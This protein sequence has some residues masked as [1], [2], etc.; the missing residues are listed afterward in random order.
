MAGRWMWENK[1][2]YSV[3]SCKTSHLW[4][5]GRC[6]S[7]GPMPF[8]W[9][10]KHM[11]WDSP[12]S[13]SQSSI[14]QSSASQNNWWTCFLLRMDNSYSFFPILRLC[15]VGCLR[16][17]RSKDLCKSVILKDT[18]CENSAHCPLKWLYQFILLTHIRIWVRVHWLNHLQGELVW[19]EE[20]QWKNRK[21]TN[22]CK[23]GCPACCEDIIK[24][25]LPCLAATERFLDIEA[26]T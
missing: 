13:C 20:S 22:C 9:R 4:A 2:Y 14:S 24:G 26:C 1:K 17:A 5:L 12:D 7:V 18:L 16:T 10:I 8:R 3:V 6:V 21:K 19:A 15:L 11:A 23:R 25:P